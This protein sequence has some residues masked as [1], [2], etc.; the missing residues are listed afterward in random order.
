MKKYEIF[1]F[2][3]DGTLYDFGK[4]EESAL[5][6]MFEQCGFDY[7]ENV[8]KRYRA[9]SAALWDA[10]EK[11]K[12]KK[13]DLQKLRFERLFD[14]FG[15]RYDALEFNDN[16]IE[17]LGEGRF[18]IDGAVEICEAIAS[19]GK[20]IF[21]VT[22]GFKR[23]QEPR[24]KNSPIYKYFSDVFISEVVGYP[25]PD[26]R[27]FDHVF[28]NIPQVSKDKILIIGDSLA[29]DIAG[30]N[31]VGIDSCWVN[32]YGVENK[33]SALPT[34]EISDLSELRKFV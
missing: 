2:D 20:P 28:S 31:K 14:E 26:E 25:K 3:A 29:A 7:S 17:K 10:Y 6:R 19:A 5:R 1:L 8:L 27:Y 13:R 23:V 24:I 33:T 16:Y 4:D 9:L 15:I 21:I 12:M 18:L 22:N 11:G 32:E 34:Y 30:G